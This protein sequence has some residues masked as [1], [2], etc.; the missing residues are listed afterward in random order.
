MKPGRA[1]TFLLSCVV[2]HKELLQALLALVALL[3]LHFM[4]LLPRRNVRYWRP[5][6]TK[7]RMSLRIVNANALT[8]TRAPPTQTA[9]VLCHSAMQ[10]ESAALN[11]SP[12]Q[13]AQLI[14]QVARQ[15]CALNAALTQT[16][17]PIGHSA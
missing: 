6:W 5:I 4:T 16:A 11:A 9:Q 12:A 8:S 7:T 1:Q 3:L 14:G 17:Q 10:E 15:D 2:A 13:I